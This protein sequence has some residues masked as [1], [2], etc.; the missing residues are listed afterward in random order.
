[1]ARFLE[2]KVTENKMHVLIFFTNCFL[3]YFSFNE[4][5]SEI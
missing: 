3:K 4:E 2:N 5:L 1:M